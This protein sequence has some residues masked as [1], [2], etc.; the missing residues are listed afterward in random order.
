MVGY[1]MSLPIVRS[2]ASIGA[3]PYGC[4]P[5]DPRLATGKSASSNSHR[6]SAPLARS[7]TPEAAL[8]H[9]GSAGPGPSHRAT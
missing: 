8:S 9:A 2:S 1:L 3:A 4:G 6:S 7:H 5:M